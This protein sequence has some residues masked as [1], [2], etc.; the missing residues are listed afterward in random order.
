MNISELFKKLPLVYISHRVCSDPSGETCF[1]HTLAT[2]AMGH[3]KLY[4][5]NATQRDATL[6]AQTGVAHELGVMYGIEYW[7]RRD[8]SR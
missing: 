4:G 6:P 3:H 8:M 7:R 5:R 1:V 2:P